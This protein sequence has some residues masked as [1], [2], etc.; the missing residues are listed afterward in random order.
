MAGLP[1]HW[2]QEFTPSTTL[3][4]Q[5]LTYLDELANITGLQVG[6]KSS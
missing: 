6:G 2:Y 1:N 4:D 5:N 3:I